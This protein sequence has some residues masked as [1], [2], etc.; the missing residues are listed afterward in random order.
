MKI[1]YLL[2]YWGASGLILLMPQIIEEPNRKLRWKDWLPTFVLAPLIFP[3][4]MIML[5]HGDAWRSHDKKRDDEKNK[6][7][8]GKSPNKEENQYLQ[9]EK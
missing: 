5:R 8:I 4:Y 6:A 7:E 9:K 1:I 3:F 2:I